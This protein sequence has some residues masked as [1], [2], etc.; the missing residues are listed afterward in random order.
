MQKVIYIV[1][2]SPK[3]NKYTYLVFDKLLNRTALYNAA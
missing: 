1:T 2:Y 3:T